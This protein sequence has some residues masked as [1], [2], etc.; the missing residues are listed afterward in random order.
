MANLHVIIGEDDYLVDST[1]RK[2]VGD[3]VGLE[4]IDSANSTNADLQLADLREA[5]SSFS[6][7]PFLDPK[8]V[9]W[10]KNVHFLP[11]GGKA[12]AADVKAA[13]E[14]FATKLGASPLPEN[15]HFIL[16]GPHLLKT[17]LFAKALAAVAEMVVFSSGKP[18]EAARE[19]TVRVI[20]LAKEAGLSF[21]RSA[22]ELFVSRVGV[23]S[24]SLMSELGKMRDY[25]GDGES[26]ITSQAI[27]EVTSQGVGVEPEVWAITDALGERNLEK[28]LAATRRF[29]QENGFA[30]LVTT[31][32]ERF[33][34]QLIEL[35][36]AA[37]GGGEPAAQ[38]MNAFAARKNAAFL[39]NWTLNELRIARWRFLSLRE[40]AV[41]SSGSVDAL[42]CLEMVRVCGVRRGAR[43]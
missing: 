28:A 38:G 29:E 39:R 40:R 27:D 30:V 8:K 10:W 31:V 15:Q 32:V 12:P 24:R 18:W 23:D 7:P 34:R 11:G 36:S 33:F 37:A 21:E 13:L 5:D 20:D 4:V 9:T 2:I 17:S 6:T 3:G 14:K 43:R 35:K 1:A 22:A 25:L 26:V 16:S 41:S 42:V 19:A